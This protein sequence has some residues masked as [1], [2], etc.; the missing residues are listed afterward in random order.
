ML[1]TLR[2][3]R[4]LFHHVA[5]LQ[6]LA[7]GEGFITIFAADTTNRHH[8]R[9]QPT[10]ATAI[11]SPYGMTPPLYSLRHLQDFRERL[12]EH[13]KD[14]RTHNNSKRTRWELE[15]ENIARALPSDECRSDTEHRSLQGAES[16]GAVVAIS[17]VT[18]RESSVSTA[19][20]AVERRYT[21]CRM[22]PEKYSGTEA[23]RVAIQAVPHSSTAIPLSSCSQPLAFACMA[24]LTLRRCTTHPH[25]L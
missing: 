18:S 6:W 22:P 2:P 11:T 10:N 13:S 25:N 12:H 17:I 16:Q 7:L 8:R 21:I 20:R 19:S 14:W 24:L 5:G 4:T 9:S 15:K 1:A 23:G 3:R